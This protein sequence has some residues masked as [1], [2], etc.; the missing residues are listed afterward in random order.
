MARIAG[1]ADHFGW[2]V[3]VVVGEDGEVVDRRR[4]ELVDEGMPGGP[5]HHDAQHLPMDEAVALVRRVEAA[6][7]RHVAAMWDDLAATLRVGAIAI[8][9]TPVVPD[10][11]EDQITDHQA[12]AKADAA[13]Y[14]RTISEDAARRGWPVHRYHQGRILAEAAA[15]LGVDESHFAAPRERLGA[16]WTLDHKRAYA[17]CLLAQRSG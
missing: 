12:Q 10:A 16:P 8:R 2:T 7:V 3:V 14:R 5:V 15:A 1:V 6:V 11:I 9:D 13:M 4:V 17:A